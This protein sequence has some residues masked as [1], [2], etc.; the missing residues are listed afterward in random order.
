MAFVPGYENDVFISYSHID[1]SKPINAKIGWVDIFEEIL[2]QRLFLRCSPQVKIFRDPALQVLGEFSQQLA[3]AISSA[4]AFISILS[5]PYVESEWCLRELRQFVDSGGVE[6]IIK[7]EKS[8]IDGI[9]DPEVAAVFNQIKDVLN[10]K[11]YEQIGNT[12]RYRDLMPDVK[13]EDIAVCYDKIDVI[14]QDLSKV[15]RE[16]RG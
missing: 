13:P 3:S 12:S 8:A 16:L 7:V 15:L 11:F 6:R 4:A 10:C 2:R 9:T 5:N 14:A 1:N